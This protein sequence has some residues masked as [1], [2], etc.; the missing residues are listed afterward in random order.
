MYDL[1]NEVW[2]YALPQAKKEAAELQSL[3]DAEGGDFKLESWDWWY[4]TEK[5]REQK[6]SLN[7]EELKPY[8]KM[9]NVR[10]GVF[11]VANR[12]FGLSFRKL[13]NVHMQSRSYEVLDVMDRTFVFIPTISTSGKMPGHDEQLWITGT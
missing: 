10:Q 7:E 8:F 5:L 9:E 2:E 3:I 11:E 4:Y 12:L 6:Y 1:L 13:D